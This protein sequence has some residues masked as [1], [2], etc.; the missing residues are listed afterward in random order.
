MSEKKQR[1][2]LFSLWKKTVT[3]NGQQV[4]VLS[5]YLGDTQISIWPNGFKKSEKSPDLVAY[6]EPRFYADPK[7]AGGPSERNGFHDPF[8]DQIP[9]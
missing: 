5:G 6:V 7:D 3:V 4:E 1:V 8:E 9:F 2:K